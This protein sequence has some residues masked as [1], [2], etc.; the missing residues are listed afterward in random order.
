MLSSKIERRMNPKSANR[1]LDPAQD[2]APDPLLSDAGSGAGQ[3]AALSVMPRASANA[4]SSDSLPT[5]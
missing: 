4:K 5:R 1:L 2:A 3:A